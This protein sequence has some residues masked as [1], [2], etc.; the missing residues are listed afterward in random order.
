MSSGK[1]RKTR[2]TS[3]RDCTRSRRSPNACTQNGTLEVGELD[4]RDGAPRRALARGWSRRRSSLVG[5][6]GRRVYQLVEL[7]VARADVVATASRAPG[8]RTAAQRRPGDGE[9]E[10]ARHRGAGGGHAAPPAAGAPA[11]K[12]RASGSTVTSQA[13]MTASSVRQSRHAWPKRRRQR[14]R[15]APGAKPSAR[16]DEREEDE[17]REPTVRRPSAPGSASSAPDE[18]R[19]RAPQAGD[20][21]RRG[22][23]RSGSPARRRS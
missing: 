2:L 15:A 5:R 18:E 17:V 16:R 19:R 3:G 22:R 4:D 10:A 20:R 23:C 14:R 7:R 11:S 8:A 1:W 12:R 21:A 9:H 6:T 13:T